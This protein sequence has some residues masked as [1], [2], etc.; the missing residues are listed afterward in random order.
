M[1]SLAA[2]NSVPLTLVSCWGWNC[3]RRVD[4]LDHHGAGGRAVALPQ[5]VAVGSVVGG[6][7][8]RAVDVGQ[9]AGRGAAAP[10]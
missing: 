5:L 3:R 4:V 1:P 2:K 10:A 7:E 6:E 9:V 8:Q